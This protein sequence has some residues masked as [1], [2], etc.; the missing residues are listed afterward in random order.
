MDST[1]NDISDAVILD[2]EGGG[3]GVIG[4]DD[5]SR[6]TMSIKS[7]RKVMY[8]RAS[9]VIHILLNYGY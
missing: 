8:G 7:A 3:G 6:F 9:S 4:V 1:V 2:W 5:L